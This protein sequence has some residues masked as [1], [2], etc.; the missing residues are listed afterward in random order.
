MTPRPH[1]WPA[2]LGSPIS[3]VG[4]YATGS[5]GPIPRTWLEL[6]PD[7]PNDADISDK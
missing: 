6:N 4:P 5:F 7:D 2:G 1:G 3:F